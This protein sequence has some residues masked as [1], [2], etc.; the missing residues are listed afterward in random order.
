MMKVIFIE[1]GKLTFNPLTVGKQ[2]SF[3]LLFEHIATSQDFS[4]APSQLLDE[5]DNDPNKV[6]VKSLRPKVEENVNWRI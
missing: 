1:N 5:Y 4:A 3:G 2:G 6:P